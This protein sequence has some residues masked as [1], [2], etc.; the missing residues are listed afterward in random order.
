MTEPQ[1]PNGGAQ[2][3]RYRLAVVIIVLSLVAGIAIALAPPAAEARITGVLTAVI[4]PV[5]CIK[6]IGSSVLHF[7]AQNRILGVL[8]ALLAIMIG[9]LTIAA[10][11]RVAGLF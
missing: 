2:S 8:M 11:T 6:C 3:P 10:L 1:K 7:R 5:A 4:L 9:L